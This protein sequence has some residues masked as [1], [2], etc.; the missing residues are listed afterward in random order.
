MLI[1][2]P[3]CQRRRSRNQAATARR[4]TPTRTYGSTLWNATAISEWR[5]QS[6]ALSGGGLHSAP[7]G[8]NEQRQGGCHGRKESREMCASGVR[9]RGTKGQQVLQRLLRKHRQSTVLRLR[10]RT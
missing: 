6:M 8:G 7:P 1:H 3:F 9:V 2:A 5:Y 4:K 10:V